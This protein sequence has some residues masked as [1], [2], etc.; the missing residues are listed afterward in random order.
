MAAM[1]RPKS[2]KPGAPAAEEKRR[3]VTS[4]DVARRAGV[5]QS[6][7]SRCFTPGAQVSAATRSKIMLAV[8]ALGYR[9]NAI[10]R[11][12]ITQR[13]NMV[14]IVVANI[15]YHP[16]LTAS[17]SRT[18]ARRGL[19]VLLFTLDHESE[20][21]QVVDRIWQY[22]V[23]GVVA[24]VH[25]PAHHVGAFARRRM[26][27]VFL[28]RLYDD[29]PANSVCCDQ[30]QGERLLVDRLIATGHR[31]FG[32]VSGPAESLVS[33]Q[34]V[35]EALERLGR[36]GITRIA[37]REGSFDYASGRRAL[38][39]LARS[40]DGLP[41]AVI[42]ANDMMA[43]GCLEALRGAGIAVP[44][45]IALAGFDDIPI[46]RYVNPPLTTAA[47]P[48]AEIGRQ[49][50]ECCA[51]LVAGRAIQVQHI[52]KPEIVIRASSAARS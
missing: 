11:S 28:N 47:V 51:D 31:S 38:N 5:S 9:P 1:T 6:Q 29:V 37:I 7:V 26:P 16:E 30:V 19:T 36:A 45:D 34:R 32:I 44:D 18:F 14:A 2:A 52:F 21:D 17:L 50:L 25:L 22:R 27:L 24:A 23:D 4:Y 35:A 48:I 41:E 49:A 33:Q 43:V 40:E 12:L 39:D 20:A 8:E 46:A 42:C 3:P 13:S 15:A 10:A